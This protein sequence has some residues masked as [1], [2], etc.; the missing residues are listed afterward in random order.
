MDLSVAICTYNGAA[1]IPEVLDCLAAQRNTDALRWEVL[2]VDNN[3]TDETA[4]V[5]RRYADRWPAS[6]RLRYVFEA[7]QGKTHAVQRAVQESTGAWI[8]FLDDDNL[9]E[10]T[11][12]AEAHGF[13]RRH[14]GA[15][16]FGGQI[17]GLFEQEPPRSFGLV[18]PLFAINKRTETVCYNAGGTPTF[19]AP[20]AGLVVR[21]R[22]WDEAVAPARLQHHGPVG[23]ERGTVGEDFELQ[24][25]LHEQGWEIWHNAAMRMKHRIP[26]E[27]FEQAYLRQFFRAIGTSRHAI[28]MLRRPRW[29]RP[30]ATVGYLAADTWK[31]L[32]LSWQ[33]RHKIRHDPFV[34]GRLRMLS[35]MIV[36]PFMLGKS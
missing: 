14:P 7:R 15:G 35:W 5:I 10:P 18:Q 11:W 21:R 12:L 32:R 19:G 17:H 16:A 2:V 30:L 31:L 26:K 6:S 23:D 13:A 22:A 34:Q 25:H 8:A 33:Y 24:W 36:R 29:Q 3:S 9:P 1:R 28:R 4:A 27:R 20:G